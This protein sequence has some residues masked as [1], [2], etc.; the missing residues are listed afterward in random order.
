MVG[1]EAL[2]DQLWAH[3][4]EVTAG[5]PLRVVSVCGAEGQ[6][7]TRLCRWLCERASELDLATPLWIEHH[8]DR[9]LGLFV[10][11][12]LGGQDPKRALR[13][14]RIQY[15]D[16][17]DPEVVRA[18]CQPSQPMA[19]RRTAL[20]RLIEAMARIRPVLL[21]IDEVA[22]Q[23]DAVALAD[24]LSELPELP[25]LVLVC[26]EATGLALIDHEVHLDP[27]TPGEIHHLIEALVGIHDG[28]TSVV[29]NRARGNPGVV[30]VLVQHLI[31]ERQLVPGPSGF[32]L[33]SGARPHVPKDLTA[34]WSDRLMHAMEG[35]DDT[36]WIGI[37]IAAV[38]GHHVD[39]DEWLACEQGSQAGLDALVEAGLLHVARHGWD[40]AHPLVVAT[41]LDRAA[42]E[43]R[44]EAH[45]RTCARAVRDPE[46]HAVHL[47]RAGAYQDCLVAL[48]APIR[49]QQSGPRRSVALL[50][51]YDQALD[52]LEVDD[53]D[54]RRAHVLHRRI[55]P[56]LSL[57]NRSEA[58]RCIDRLRAHRHRAGW[59]GPATWALV[60]QAILSPGH[61]PQTLKRLEAA[62]IEAQDLPRGDLHA[63]LERML[64]STLVRMGRH[65]E[66]D[67]WIQQA[68][69]IQAPPAD[70]TV[71]PMTR[72]FIEIW[73]AAKAPNLMSFIW[74]DLADLRTQQRRPREAVAAAQRALAFPNQRLE[75]QSYAMVQLGKA[76]RMMGDLNKAEATLVQVT[77]VH[78][79]P[80]A[81]ASMEMAILHLIRGDFAAA[82]R[83]LHETLQQVAR[84]SQHEIRATALLVDTVI[85][86]G[87]AD[88]NGY[89][90]SIEQ[91]TSLLRK[92]D[93]WD[94]DIPDLARRARDMAASHPARAAAAEALL[95]GP[96]PGSA[97]PP[98]D[99]EG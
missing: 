69:T 87:L 49:T 44:L 96:K 93:N 33:A 42:Q 31:H 26:G 77:S 25:I 52:A 35:L 64:A 81:W 97:D 54:A 15:G 24:A 40:F 9:G 90:R 95:A 82:R 4:G 1:R 79:L 59:A 56:A 48:V 60:Y 27:M 65:T 39:P 51:L 38:L 57:G 46:R 71:D 63:N 99:Q 11:Q 29:Q 37:Q 16:G 75:T 68:L 61:S 22:S 28:L 3:L 8:P 50:D 21:V 23:D 85:A 30:E 20:T 91:A 62:W 36:A 73:D 67:H 6:G 47:F 2:R 80:R 13:T 14:L 34:A 53:D 32:R 83:Q 18:L 86:A 98:T 89:D 72:L 5:G 58:Q 10:E 70:E 43:G 74:R 17:I 55:N 88:W 78:A 66:A 84:F 92:L 19:E 76:Y 12:L 41:I 7:K 45:H 94:V